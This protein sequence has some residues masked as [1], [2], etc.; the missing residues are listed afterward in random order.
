MLLF[1]FVS[2]MNTNDSQPIIIL[3]DDRSSALSFFSGKFM[4]KL[5]FSFIDPD[6]DLF[7]L[8]IQA[9]L[10]DITVLSFCIFATIFSYGIAK[11]RQIF[12]LGNLMS[13]RVQRQELCRLNSLL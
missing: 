13:I 5:I 9:K 10:I 1:L 12:F 8:L 7:T 6:L 4:Q 11:N 2:F 3:E